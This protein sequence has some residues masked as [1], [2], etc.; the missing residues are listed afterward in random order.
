MLLEHG[1]DL[2]RPVDEGL[3]EA[4]AQRRELVIEPRT[5]LLVAVFVGN[6]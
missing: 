2:R 5:R 3:I 4:A 6:D 1:L